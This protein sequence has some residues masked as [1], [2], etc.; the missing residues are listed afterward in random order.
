MTAGGFHA[1]ANRT[2]KPDF[3]LAVKSRRFALIPQDTPAAGPSIRDDFGVATL[4]IDG[5]AVP[6]HFRHFLAVDLSV[7]ESKVKTC[8]ANIFLK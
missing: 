8:V 7:T 5:C 1:P 3:P 6:N 4:W 2:M